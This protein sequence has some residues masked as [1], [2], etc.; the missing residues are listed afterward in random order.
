M[1][2]GWLGAILLV[3]GGLMALYIGPMV[4]ASMPFVPSFNVFVPTPSPSI[5]SN[6]R[7][8]ASMPTGHHALGTWNIFMPA[9]WDVKGDA[10]VVDGNVVAQGTMSVDVDC[11]GSV[12]T[13]GPFNLIDTPV[14]GPEVPDAEWTG[15]ITP[16]WSLIVTVDHEPGEP[17]DLGADL[18]N[19][20]EF[21]NLCAPQT[22]A[23]NILGRSSPSN[24]VV[25]TN[26]SARNLRLGQQL[27]QL[28]WG[29]YHE[30]E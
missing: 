26:P 12:D 25:L 18:T 14:S 8:T 9:G 19:F 21:H 29:T 24:N 11:N 6:L 13:Y 16:W 2:R 27:L 17:F 4:T 1:I 20:N 28:R 30:R 22:F 5:N 15:Q 10:Q 7:I 23:L 3:A